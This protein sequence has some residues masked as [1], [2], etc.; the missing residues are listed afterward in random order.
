MTEPGDIHDAVYCAVDVVWLTAW[1]VADAAGAGQYDI[2]AA[3]D[4]GARFIR[5]VG[6]SQADI[7]GP[8]C[9]DAELPCSRRSQ[10]EGKAC[11]W[12]RPA[13]DSG[14]VRGKLRS[15]RESGNQTAHQER[16]ASTE[17]DD[18]LL[19][20]ENRNQE[21]D[22]ANRKDCASRVCERYK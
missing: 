21:G 4:A 2:R 12:P 11:R 1:E 3:G 8:R 18:R 17:L 6:L 15:K 9:A 19:V 13:S 5:P 14:Q 20:A 16:G 10:Q 22:Y 7:R